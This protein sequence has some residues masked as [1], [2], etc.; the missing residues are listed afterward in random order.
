MDVKLACLF[1]VNFHSF[2]LQKIPKTTFYDK[3]HK[4]RDEIYKK[5]KD[6]P[7]LYDTKKVKKLADEALEICH[8]IEEKVG[9]YK[10]DPDDPEMPTYPEFDPSTYPQYRFVECDN[11]MISK[12][13]VKFDLDYVIETARNFGRSDLE[14]NAYLD[15]PLVRL[16]D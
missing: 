15:A 8:Y 16:E 9:L 11:Y 3:Y 10:E 6:K 5:L 4:I 1:E 2:N 7:I 13:L 14:K 12:G